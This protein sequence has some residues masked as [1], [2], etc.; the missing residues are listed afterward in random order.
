MGL[1]DLSGI[2]TPR[3]TGVTA[4][5]SL[6]VLHLRQRLADAVDEGTCGTTEFARPVDKQNRDRRHL[7]KRVQDSQEPARQ[8]ARN[9]TGG[10][11][12]HSRSSLDQPLLNSNAGTDVEEP[13]LDARR[14]KPSDHLPVTDRTRLIGDDAG[15]YKIGRRQ[16]PVEAQRGAGHPGRRLQAQID[17]RES[18]EIGGFDQ[19]GEIDPAILQ[20]GFDGRTDRNRQLRVQVRILRMQAIEN[21]R[22]APSCRRTMSAAMSWSNLFLASA[23]RSS[24][25]R[26]AS[27]APSAPRLT[28]TVRHRSPA[29]CFGILIWNR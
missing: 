15:S 22:Q 9:H 29:S 20:C 5:S 8:L 4:S 28:R 10:Q 24:A 3:R 2:T 27:R 25:F 26:C 17:L 6:E 16:R 12:T 21:L 18:F 19:E 1:P 7:R 13:G 14:C 23:A 11:D